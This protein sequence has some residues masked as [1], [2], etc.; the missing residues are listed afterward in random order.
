MLN[1][2]VPKLWALGPKA[3]GFWVLTPDLDRIYLEKDPARFRKGV[4]RRSP[5]N[6][7]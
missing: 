3:L 7:S 4:D 1:Q 6:D 2:H 5:R